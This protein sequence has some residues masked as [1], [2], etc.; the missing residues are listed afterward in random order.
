MVLTT[1][2]PLLLCNLHAPPEDYRVT[3]YTGLSRLL[4]G[5]A[6]SGE[7][8]IRGMI[9]VMVTIYCLV[10]VTLQNGHVHDLSVRQVGHSGRLV[11]T[12]KNTHVHSFVIPDS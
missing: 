5:L 10:V 2:T 11:R 1:T 3:C 7:V 6:W 4:T 9:K 12:S 8:P